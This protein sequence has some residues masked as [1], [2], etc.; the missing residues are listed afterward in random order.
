MVR[1]RRYVPDVTEAHENHID[2][3]SEDYACSY[4]L[5]L[6]LRE[7]FHHDGECK[8]PEERAETRKS[9]TVRQNFDEF[10]TVVGNLHE[11]LSK[12]DN[13]SGTYTAKFIKLVK[14]AHNRREKFA[15]IMED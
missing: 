9:G 2:R 7:I 10:M 15:R 13:P 4:G 12:C 8:T 5:M 1:L 11:K 6:C 14:H 3:T